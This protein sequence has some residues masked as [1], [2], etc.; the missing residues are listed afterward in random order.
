[1][2][3]DPPLIQGLAAYAEARQNELF[4]EAQDEA[5]ATTQSALFL[6][7]WSAADYFTTNQRL[8][9]DPDLVD[10]EISKSFRLEYLFDRALI[11]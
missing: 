2:F 1:M 5:E 11:K 6:R 8:M 3:D 10:V 7:I 9:N 4:S